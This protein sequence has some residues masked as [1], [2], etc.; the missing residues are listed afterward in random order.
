MLLYFS[1]KS[2]PSS[3]GSRVNG[4]LQYIHTSTRPNILVGFWQ[5]GDLALRHQLDLFPSRAVADNLHQLRADEKA[6]LQQ[7][8]GIT[9][10]DAA[11]LVRAC[12]LYTAATPARLFAYQLEDLVLLDTPVNIPGTSTEYANWQRKL[13]QDI[14]TI[15][16]EPTVIKLMQEM[17]QARG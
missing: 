10:P 7:Q 9:E 8:L 12:H 1:S 15:L 16:T 3:A 2:L 4:S 13:P 11:T 6:I 5:E 14:A 17:K